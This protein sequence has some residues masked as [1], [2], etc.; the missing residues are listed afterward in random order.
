MK[1]LIICVGKKHDALLSPS[2]EHYE[3]RLKH[4][5]RVEWQIIPSSDI[6]SESSSICD[7]L[8]P[9]DKVVLLDE[10][11]KSVDNVGL[12][13]VIEQTQNNAVDRLVLIIG[14]AYGVN[15]DVKSRADYIFSLSKLVF[16]HQLVRLILVEQLYR[17]YS[18]LSGSKYHHD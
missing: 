18:I 6:G 16:P 3:G 5:V 2:I 15:D 12:A 8:K 7:K 4:F 10:D 17:S 11:G 13:Q 14:G 9:N 1:I